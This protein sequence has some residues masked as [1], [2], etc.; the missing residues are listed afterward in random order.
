MLFAPLSMERSYADACRQRLWGPG[1]TLFTGILSPWLKTAPMGQQVGSL[2]RA[3]LWPRYAYWS[4]GN[5]NTTGTL[6][7]VVSLIA[8]FADTA[9]ASGELVSDGGGRLP[10]P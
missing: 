4:S 9:S 7:F 10:T 3:V 6:V 2:I 5:S 8:K 1:P